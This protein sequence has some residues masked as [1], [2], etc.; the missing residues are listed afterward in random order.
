VSAPGVTVLFTAFAEPSHQQ[1]PARAWQS[2]NAAVGTIDSTGLFMV[3]DRLSGVVTVR[4][5]WCGLTG[6]TTL[7]VILDLDGSAD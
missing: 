5:G 3:S 6:H 1:V 2:D 4:G 7:T